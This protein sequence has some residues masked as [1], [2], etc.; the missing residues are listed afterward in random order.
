MPS[1]E[2]RNNYLWEKIPPDAVIDFIQNITIHPSCFNASPKVVSQYIQN[3]IEDGELVEWTVALVST[4]SGEP[5]TISGLPIGLTWRSDDSQNRNSKKDTIYLIRNNL[6]TETDQD[7]DLTD[8][9][10]KR[11]FELT[12]ENWKPSGRSSTPPTETSPKQVRN[13]RN[14]KKA[15]LL[16]YIFQS[17]TLDGNNRKP[18]DG[19]YFWHM[20]WLYAALELQL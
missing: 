1:S 7:V 11:A 20:D 12:L 5:D 10:K 6:I 4:L 15:L 16:I 13:A 9:E 19:K 18:Y 8:D 14:K 3:Q 2:T 17:G